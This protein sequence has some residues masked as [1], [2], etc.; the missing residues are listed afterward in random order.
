MYAIYYNV[1]TFLWDIIRF[2]FASISFWLWS[3]YLSEHLRFPVWRVNYKCPTSPSPESR[4]AS[5]LPHSACESVG[6]T[7]SRR[8][9]NQPEHHHPLSSLQLWGHAIIN[10]TITWRASVAENKAST[11]GEVTHLEVYRVL[12]DLF[13]HSREKVSHEN[14]K[15]EHSKQGV[16]KWLAREGQH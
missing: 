8:S 6:L 9:L 3:R 7:F 1:Y 10:S 15:V 16:Y 5:S 12:Q 14:L 4:G 2:H 11:R 13:V